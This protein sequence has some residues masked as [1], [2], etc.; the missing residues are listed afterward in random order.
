MFRFEGIGKKP[1]I[2]SKTD[3]YR[4]WPTIKALT[5]LTSILKIYGEQI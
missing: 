5:I 3:L 2:I 4:I 1:Q